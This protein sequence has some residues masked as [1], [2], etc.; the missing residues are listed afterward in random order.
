ML[1]ALTRHI[2]HHTAVPV[3]GGDI[4]RAYRV[5]TATAT[6]FA[7]TPL[8]P[9]PQ[10]FA[11]EAWG[12]RRLDAVVPGLTPEVV[13]VSTDWL[14]LAWVDSAPPTV[15]AARALGR[16]LAQL[17]QAHAGSFGQG[18]QPARIGSLPMPSGDFAT[19]PQMYAALRLEPLLGPGLA[20]CHAVVES[21]LDD[22]DWAGPPEPAS[23][24]HGD[25][26]SGNVLWTD[27]APLLIDP[28]SHVGHRETDLAMLALFGT[29][30]LADMIA[31]Y[32]ELYPLAPGWQDRVGLHQLWPLLV[33]HR[34]FAGGYGQRA[35]QLARQYLR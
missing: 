20:N 32:Q 5:E 15:A 17:H 3:G 24:L 30:H 31:A 25:L 13:H 35:E 23:L 4:C 18:P 21:L 14:V 16:S 7:K 19:W 1:E 26:W 22:P 33:H 12:L 11:A 27:D 29:P 2:G 9:D 6:Y 34:L 8:R 10:M 28:A